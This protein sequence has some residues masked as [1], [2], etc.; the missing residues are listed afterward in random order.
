MRSSLTFSIGLLF[1]S[2]LA[3]GCGGSSTTPTAQPGLPPGE[4]PTD[5]DISR[6]DAGSFTEDRD[7]TPPIETKQTPEPVEEIDPALPHPFLSSYKQIVGEWMTPDEKSRLDKV[8]IDATKAA[9][10]RHLALMLRD[11]ILRDLVPQSLSR[12]RVRHLKTMARR[13]QGTP[14]VVP[15]RDKAGLSIAAHEVMYTAFYGV[16]LYQVCELNCEWDEK[17]REPCRACREE[18]KKLYPLITACR[19]IDP[20]TLQWQEIGE[21]GEGEIPGIKSSPFITIFESSQ[22]AGVPRKKIVKFAISVLK[23]MVKFAKGTTTL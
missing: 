19:P 11:R 13:L 22:E 7:E 16:P 9:N 23:K 18:S 5:A 17:A 12:S 2:L 3:A 4:A 10:E 8:S 20:Q 14:V 15:D 1:G 6:V 21:M